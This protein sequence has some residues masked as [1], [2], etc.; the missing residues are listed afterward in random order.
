MV[1]EIDEIRDLNKDLEIGELR[2]RLTK[3]FDELK[4]LKAKY[5]TEQPETDIDTAI[6]DC[7]TSGMSL[8]QTANKLGLNKSYVYRRVKAIRGN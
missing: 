5:E 7:T 6:T 1:N 4:R 8:Q 3:A 2:E